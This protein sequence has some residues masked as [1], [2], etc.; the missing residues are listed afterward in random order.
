MSGEDRRSGGGGPRRKLKAWG[1]RQCKIDVGV[2]T[3]LTTEIWAST[4]INTDTGKVDR[5]LSRKQAVCVHC[6]TRGKITEA[7]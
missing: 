5:K 6:L 7:F 3:T 1:C 2:A 4:V